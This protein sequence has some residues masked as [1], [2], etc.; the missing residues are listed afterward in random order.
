[1]QNKDESHMKTWDFVEVEKPGKLVGFYIREVRKGV[2]ILA[3]I[4]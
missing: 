3:G 4:D 1:M 2:N